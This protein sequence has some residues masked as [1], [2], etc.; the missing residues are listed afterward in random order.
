[1]VN[2]TPEAYDELRRLATG[3]LSRERRAHT[4]QPTALVHEALA[5]LMA[6][7]GAGALAGMDRGEYVAAVARA[8]RLVLVDH[9]RRR[10]AQK[11]GGARHRV[12]LDDSLALYEESASDLL[13]LDEALE[14][15]AALDPELARMVELRFFGGLTEEETAREMGVSSRTV[16]RAWRF[17]RVWLARELGEEATREP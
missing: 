3:Y 16:T 15:L 7:R 1:V 4:L 17:A 6:G 2:G 10:G 11:R 13:A 12:P 8:M 9:A 14:R 5:R